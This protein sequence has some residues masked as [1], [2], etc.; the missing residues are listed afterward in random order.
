MT[1]VC[2]QKEHEA[3]DINKSNIAKSGCTR[4]AAQP[5]GA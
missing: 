1:D 5:T 2:A 4:G 3:E